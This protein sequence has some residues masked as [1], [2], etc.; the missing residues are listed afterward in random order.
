MCFAVVLRDVGSATAFLGRMIW[1]YLGHALEDDVS[2]RL[3]ARVS[4]WFRQVNRRA[5]MLRRSSIIAVIFVSSTRPDWELKSASFRA[6][7]AAREMS[8]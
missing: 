2:T 1:L 6:S 7:S 8:A 4:H 3:F 5:A